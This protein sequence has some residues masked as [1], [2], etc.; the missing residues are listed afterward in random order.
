[1][2]KKEAFMMRRYFSVILMLV[3]LLAVAPAQALYVDFMPYPTPVT[4]E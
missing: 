4:S 1:M 2:D 3:L